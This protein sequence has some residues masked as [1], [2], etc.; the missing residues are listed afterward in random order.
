LTA[1]LVLGGA[2][3]VWDDVKAALELGEFSGVVAANDVGAEWPGHLDAWVSLHADKF[4]LWA[5]RRAKR[6][7]APA[8]AVFAH[9]SRK[10]TAPGVTH[11]TEW[12]FPGQRET[13]SSGLFALKVA[14]VDLGF[15]KAVLC[16]V[17]MSVDGAHFF[18]TR[19]W[20]AAMSHRQGWS[21]ALPHIKHKARS[22][23]GF[24]ADLLG[25]PTTEWLGG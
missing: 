21:E 18:D 9:E 7:F 4:K 16:G 2:A 5:Q 10:G 23:G 25:R 15:D 12:K 17:P 11:A 19:P 3:T 8:A 20:R 24:T 1:A 13:G 6:G 14:L 22:M